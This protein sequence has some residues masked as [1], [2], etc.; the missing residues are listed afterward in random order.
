MRFGWIG[1]N[2][3]AELKWRLVGLYW[4]VQA[5]VIYLFGLLWLAAV[6]T[7]DGPKGNLWGLPPNLHDLDLM[8]VDWQYLLCSGGVALVVTLAQWA[9]LAPVSRP[10]ARADGS[11]LGGRGVP[12]W[13]SVG[14]AGLLIGSLAAAGTLAV[15]GLAR[16]LGV[17]GWLMGQG[18]WLVAGALAMA[19]AVST[20]LLL[21]FVRRGRSEDAL[22]RLARLLFVGTI[23][24]AAAIMPMDVIVRRRTSCYCWAETYF[25]LTVCGAVALAVCGPAALLVAMS[26]RRKR[27]YGG[28]CDVCGYDMR[29]LAKAERCPECGAGWGG[30]GVKLQN[31]KIAKLKAGG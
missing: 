28:R 24:E 13:V 3:A 26:A 17:E 27:W 23:V 5:V 15:L 2:R 6:G 31:D 14:G 20:P 22:A 30:G 19:W 29:G 21:G 18:G 25:A 12:L 11:V 16:E 10:R 1:A 8:A 9:L 4:V 7:V